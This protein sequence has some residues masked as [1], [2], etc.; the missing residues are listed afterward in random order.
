MIQDLHIVVGETPKG[1]VSVLAATKDAAKAEK[2]YQEAKGDFQTVAMIS[3]AFPVK[4][5]FPIEEVMMAKAR[6]EQAAAAAKAEENAIK[7]K[8]VEEKAKAE[9]ATKAA[10]DAAAALAKLK[11]PAK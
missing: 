3:H 9:A 2:A 5:R 8:I 7:A 4:N 1:D 10:E 6:E 11:K